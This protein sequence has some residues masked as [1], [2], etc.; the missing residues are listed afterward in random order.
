[1][2]IAHRINTVAELKKVPQ[3]M[4][5]EID[6]RDYNGEL[7]LQHDPFIGGE[8][9]SEY[10]KYYRHSTMILNIKS[11]GVEWKALEMLDAEGIHDFFFLDL[12]MTSMFRMFQLGEKRVASRFSVFEPF[13]NTLAI[14]NNIEWV[15]V[16]TLNEFPLRGED[17]LLMRNLNLR[18]C[19]TSPDL[20]DRPNQI[21]LYKSLCEKREIQFDAV[22]C[23][24]ENVSLWESQE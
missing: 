6:L 24:L 2:Y 19:L 14:A 5:V 11:Q 20:L 4:G 13:E 10:L 8:L 18:F 7:V 16:D 12:S 15:W 23:K 22:C 1:M 9:F 21:A 17:Y 3:E